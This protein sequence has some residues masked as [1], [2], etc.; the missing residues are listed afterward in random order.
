MNITRPTEEQREA[1]AAWWSERLRACKNS[2]LSDSERANPANSVYE[3]GEM[4][5][6]LARPSVSEEQVERFRT[7]LLRRLSEAAPFES[8]TLG[9]DYGADR[10]LADS[11]AEAEIPDRIGTLPIKTVMWLRDD[12]TVAVRYGYGAPIEQIYPNDSIE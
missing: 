2:G 12:N 9:V 7:A 5:M 6:D 11:L 10:L 1:A 4:L 8:R 3:L